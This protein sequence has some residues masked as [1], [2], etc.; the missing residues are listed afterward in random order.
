MHDL[1]EKT[2]AAGVRIA[3]IFEVLICPDVTEKLLHFSGF[4]CLG[5]PGHLWRMVPHCDSDIGKCSPAQ[6]VAQIQFALMAIYAA[7]GCK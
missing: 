7:F 3:A 4:K 1:P 2:F 5:L 6:P